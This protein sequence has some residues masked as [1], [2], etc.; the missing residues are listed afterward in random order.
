MDRL[1]FV[2]DEC[3]ERMKYLSRML[4]DFHSPSAAK[5]YVFPPNILLTRAAV[6]ELSDGSFL[7]YGRITDDAL[8]ILESKGIKAFCML[9][10][11]EFAAKN[12]ALT[13][14]AALSILIDRPDVGLAGL[15]VL[16]VGF[17]RVG[18]ALANLL[19]RLN[20]RT[21]IATSAS[22]RPA[23]AFSTCVIP[24]EHI[25]FSPYNAVVN[26]APARIA[27]DQELLSLKAGTL[28]VELASNPSVNLNFAK[29][30]GVDADIYPALPTKCSPQSAAQIIA[31]FVVEKLQTSA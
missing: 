19:C 29:Y 4:C 20:V 23:R 15:N 14:E 12:A 7:C 10:D 27:T 9:C 3:D 6:K 18:A 1:C 5:C 31:D 17:G 2:L 24:L 22:A 8:P 28:F 30:I 26:T 13:A 25:D 21:T 16:I 11:E